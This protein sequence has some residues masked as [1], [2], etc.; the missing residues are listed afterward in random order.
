MLAGVSRSGYYAWKKNK[1]KRELKN[2]E[3]KKD[4]E[5]ILQAYSFK[6]RYK[7]ARGIKMVLFRQFGIV[8]NLKKIRR[9]MKKY[10]LTCPI[11]KKNPYR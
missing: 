3:D 8:M 4:F 7:G 2:A 1:I 9:L 11:R 5:K 10:H 6:N